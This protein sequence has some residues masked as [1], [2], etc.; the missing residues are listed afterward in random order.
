MPWWLC[1]QMI[2]H[3]PKV[4]KPLMIGCLYRSKPFAMNGIL[5]LPWL[6]LGHQDSSFSLAHLVMSGNDLDGYLRELSL[7]DKERLKQYSPRS[8][9]GRAALILIVPIVSMQLVVSIVFIK[10]DLEDVTTQ[11]TAT[12]MQQIALRSG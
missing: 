10:R 7:E 6:V 2:C 5:C 12:V 3:P 8:L 1:R 11:M 9:Y 4:T